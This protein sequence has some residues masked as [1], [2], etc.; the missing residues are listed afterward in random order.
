MTLNSK[1]LVLFVVGGI[2]IALSAWAGKIYFQHV[3]VATSGDTLI[4][5]VTDKG[6][7]G[8]PHIGGSFR[9]IDHHGNPRTDA[10][11]KGKYVMV[12]FGYSFCPD[13]CPAALTNMSEAL[14]A[15]KEK[16]E[17]V[18][19]LF[20]TID[21]ERD[22]IAHLARYIESFHPRFIALTGEPKQIEKVKKAYRVYGAKTKP[23]GTSTDYIMDH[24][25]IIYVMDRQG[26]FIA[27]FNHATPP[28]EMVRVLDEL[29]S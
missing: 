10:D 13:I 28:H 21:P 23:D 3:D 25:S 15:L 9:L 12:Y 1:I 29:I 8:L 11:F 6:G 16:A 7:T 18:H 20:I 27:H 24:S 5:E 26:R 14:A 2:C 4:A 19:S 17:Q 22:T